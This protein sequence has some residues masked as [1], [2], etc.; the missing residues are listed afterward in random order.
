MFNKLLKLIRLTI[1]H[2]FYHFRVY[3]GLSHDDLCTLET[4]LLID[5]FEQPLK[6]MEDY[7]KALCHV[8][9]CAPDLHQY[10]QK[11]VLPAPG[12]WPTWYYQ[13]KIIAQEL[14]ENSNFLS[15]IPEQG[16]FH[17]FLNLQEDVL[18]MYHFILAKVYKDIF[19]SD[20]PTK[21]KPFRIHLLITAVFLGWL[22]IRS[23]VLA[24]FKLCK[25]IEY[26]C[27]LHLLDEVI[28][29]SF[30]HYPV[31]FRSGDLD[32]Y[33][34]TMLRLLVLFIIWKRKHYDRSTLSMLSD[35]CYHKMFFPAYY[36]L[37]KL[38]MVLITEKKVEIWN[39]VL[40]RNI[41]KHNSAQEI[42]N[43]A[44]IIAAS[45]SNKSFQDHFANQYTRG[46]SEKDISVVAGK[47][48]KVILLLIKRIGQNLGKSKQVFIFNKIC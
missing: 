26:A 35:L 44:T 18:K 41:Q 11:F 2:F 14:N 48:A 34:A 46:N 9:E 4:T 45:K 25:D 29:I 28:P 8:L 19:G 1:G 7:K 32:C 5:E 10:L 20:L 13:K 33:I 23:K 31:T 15:I 17:V 36:N 37:K 43:K 3:S 16:P 12:D 42:Q 40:R 21:P 30:Y 24:K 22:K 27:F 39:G 6:S 47:A 38:W